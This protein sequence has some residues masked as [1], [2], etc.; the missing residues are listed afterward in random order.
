MSD[1][2]EKVI[3]EQ[4]RSLTSKVKRQEMEI[5]DLRNQLSSSTSVVS[6]RPGVSPEHRLFPCKVT[7]V[8]DDGTSLTASLIKSDRT[9]DSALSSITVQVPVGGTAPEVDDEIVAIFLGIDS[10]QSVYILTSGAAGGG[11]SFPA[12]ITS[13]IDSTHFQVDLYQDGYSSPATDTSKEAYLVD[14]TSLA[15]SVGDQVSVFID[16]GAYYISTTRI[17][18]YNSSKLVQWGKIF[19]SGSTYVVKLYD[20][21]ASSTLRGTI[22]AKEAN[23]CSIVPFDTWVPVFYSPVTGAYW[24]FFPLGE[25]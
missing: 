21:P 11:G 25:V 4:I 18:N 3:M 7:A 17:L 5:A 6:T 2:F 12:K 1:N 9:A 15:F 13:V 10:G 14:G 16:N 24:F 23:G 22:S 20:D 8:V 19:S